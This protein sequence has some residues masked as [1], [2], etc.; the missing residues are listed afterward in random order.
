MCKR[1]RESMCK[2]VMKYACVWNK[3]K[4]SE[5]KFTSTKYEKLIDKFVWVMIYTVYIL[6]HTLYL[7]WYT[8]KLWYFKFSYQEDKPKQ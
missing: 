3:E 5:H 6:I 1:E 4:L 7:N 2:Y 8:Y